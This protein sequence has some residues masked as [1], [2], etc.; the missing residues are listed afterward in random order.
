MPSGNFAQ[1]VQIKARGLV[2]QAITWT[3]V[4][5]SFSC[6]KF[7]TK[8]G[9]ITATL[10]QN[11]KMI[12]Q[13]KYMLPTYDFSSNECKMRFEDSLYYMDLGASWSRERCDNLMPPKGFYSSAYPGILPYLTDS[14]ELTYDLARDAPRPAG[15][16]EVETLTQMLHG[17]QNIL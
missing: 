11:F 4:N 5:L 10:L 3:S 14:S 6:L 9:I 16:L 13:L 17:I 7:Y 12:T 2:A 15:L 8:H 1:L